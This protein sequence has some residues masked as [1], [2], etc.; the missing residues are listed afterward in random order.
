MNTEMPSDP[1]KPRTSTLLI[2]AFLLGVLTVL[3]FVLVT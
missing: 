2:F 1:K 3:V